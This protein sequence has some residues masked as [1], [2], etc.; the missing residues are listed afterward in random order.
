[1]RVVAVGGRSGVQIVPII[2]V[3]CVA[4]RVSA[5]LLSS[6]VQARLSFSLRLEALAL[7]IGEVDF[8]IALATEP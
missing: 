5:Q 2:G 7:P 4:A 8:E 6:V 3:D 1:V